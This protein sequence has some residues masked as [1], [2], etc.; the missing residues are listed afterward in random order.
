MKLHQKLIPYCNIP[1][2]CS[3]RNSIRYQWEF[4]FQMCWRQYLSSHWHKRGS[5]FV[6]QEKNKTS[7]M[8]SPLSFYSNLKKRRAKLK[9]RQI[10]RGQNNNTCKLIT[11]KQHFFNK[12][13]TAKDN[14]LQAL[15][16]QHPNKQCYREANL[17]VWVF[18][19]N[20]TIF[21]TQQMES[22]GNIKNWLRKL[23]KSC[24]S[25]YTTKEWKALETNY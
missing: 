19:Q 15:H 14:R 3:W 21:Q 4:H 24:L 7:M 20:S 8:G 12:H 9:K 11:R 17:N 5:I 25:A 22:F 23:E 1:N 10:S 2:L 16:I 13:W 18:V 6:S